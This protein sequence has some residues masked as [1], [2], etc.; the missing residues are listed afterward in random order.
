MQSYAYDTQTIICYTQSSKCSNV[1]FRKNFGELFNNFGE[2]FHNFGE[3]SRQVRNKFKMQFCN[4][5]QLGR[6]RLTSCTISMY[7]F[8]IFHY[9]H[10]SI[11]VNLGKFCQV[12]VNFGSLDPTV[13]DHFASLHSILVNFASFRLTGF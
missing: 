11:L 13:L 5:D 1:K 12:L 2:L 8:T 9:T 7:L 6:G 3:L 4:L 10:W